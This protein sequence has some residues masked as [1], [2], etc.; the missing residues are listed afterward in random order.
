MLWTHME[1]GSYTKVVG[2]KKASWRWWH[3]AEPCWR[4][5][6][7]K[8]KGQVIPVCQ[9]GGARSMGKNKAL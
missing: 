5:K 7:R 2:S 4:G 3:I 6:S 1:K 8:M 9:A